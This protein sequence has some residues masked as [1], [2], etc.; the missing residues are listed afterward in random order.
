MFLLS[1]FITKSYLFLISK[2]SISLFV[3]NL[4]QIFLDFLQVLSDKLNKSIYL[5]KKKFFLF[6]LLNSR[7]SLELFL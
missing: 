7:N 4:K 6:S 5:I 2:F 3:T 1:E